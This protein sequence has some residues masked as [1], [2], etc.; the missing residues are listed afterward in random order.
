WRGKPEFAG[1]G[2]RLTIDMQ[3]DAQRQL[4]LADVAITMHGVPA[5]RFTLRERHFSRPAVL[6]ALAAAGLVPIT[7]QPW[8]PFD[9]DLAGKTWW[10]ARLERSP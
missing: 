9:G 10:V 2:W 5:G 4:G 3:F 8:A 6:Q 7:E 1:D